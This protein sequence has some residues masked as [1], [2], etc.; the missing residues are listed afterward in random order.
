MRDKVLASSAGKTLP[1]VIDELVTALNIYHG[2]AIFSRRVGKG[3]IE[4][5]SPAAPGTINRST[6]NESVIR[7]MY[8][9]MVTKDTDSEHSFITA[10][11][12][13][14]NSNYPASMHIKILNKQGEAVSLTD[15]NAVRLAFKRG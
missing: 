1:T 5:A 14:L 10:I 4:F 15:E 9:K 13:I 2:R 7:F 6:R 3:D 12:A 11:V 8:H